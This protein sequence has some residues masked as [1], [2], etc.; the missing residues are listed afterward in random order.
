MQLA[1]AAPPLQQTHHQNH[2]TNTPISHVRTKPFMKLY[3]LFTKLYP[4]PR[5]ARRREWGLNS[6]QPLA[7][8]SGKQPV[9]CG[10]WPVAVAVAV[11]V[12]YGL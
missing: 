3:K 6:K 1:S 5:S 8:G 4:P 2:A 9:A 7:C 12:V 10:L 11:A